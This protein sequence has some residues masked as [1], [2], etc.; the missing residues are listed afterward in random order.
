MIKLSKLLIASH[1]KGKIAEF[2]KLFEDFKIEVTSLLDYP[3]IE[4]VEE[5]GSTFEENA[6]LKAETI[7]NMLNTMVLA[8]DSGLSV[9]TLDGR[10]GVFSARYAGEHGNDALNNEKLLND[11]KGNSHRDAHFT[12]CLVLAHPKMPSLVVEGQADGIILEEIKG[13]E[14]FGY[15]PLF[16][17]ESEQK[18]F[19]ELTAERKNEISHRGKAIKK[20]MAAMPEWL[21]ELNS[22]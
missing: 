19:A 8:D 10:P 14:G 5:T 7:A 4:E 18:T 13:T 9:D 16:Y 6:R 3:E 21:E 1:N 20:L 2:A 11:L 17:V 22:K 15:D 12:C